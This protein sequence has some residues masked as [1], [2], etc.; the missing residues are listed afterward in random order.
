MLPHS[1]RPPRRRLRRVGSWLAGFVALVGCSR[2]SGTYVVLD[3]EGAVSSQAAIHS[4]EVSLLMGGAQAS[5]V[6]S[7]PGGGDITLSTNATLKIEHGSGPLTVAA[8][9]KSADGQV[10]GTGTGSGEVVAGQ[11]QEI[12][13][14]FTSS[15]G[16]VGPDGGIG[17]DSG[18]DS[19]IDL[20]GDV[21]ADAPG[22]PAGSDRVGD[23]DSG[24]SDL[25]N[26]GADSAD[27][28]VFIDV[29]A[30]ADAAGGV[31]GIN[32]GD[33]AIG[34][35]GAGGAG[36]VAGGAGG[37][38]G[39]AGGAGGIGGAGGAGG[40]GGVTGAGG[41]GGATSAGGTG[42]QDADPDGPGGATAS[43]G[44]SAGGTTGVVALVSEP[45]GLV[46]GEVAVGSKSAP[47]S[48]IIRN[49]GNL[50]APPL[51]IKPL[52]TT[53][54]FALQADAC[55]GKNLA[56]NETCTLVLIFSPTGFGAASDVLT[57]TV[58]GISGTDIILTGTGTTSP[59]VLTLQPTSA[60][61]G[62]VDVGSTG[63]VT[64]TLSNSGGSSS[65]LS[66]VTPSDA[67]I[68]PIASNQCGSL[69]AA[70]ASCTF[71]LNFAP[72]A[73]GPVNGTVSVNPLDATL[74]G[75]GRAY[76]TLTINQTGSGNGTISGT[77]LTCQ[78]GVCT[79]KYATT[80]PS[81]SPAAP[82]VTVTATPD[83]SSTF[84]GWL[85]GGCAG[86][87]TCTVTLGSPMTLSAT[88]TA[89][90]VHQV[91]L[92]AF[93]LASHK[94][95][96]VSSDGVLSCSGSC[97]P[98]PYPA[99]AVVT[100]SANPNPG[101]TFIGWTH[102][103]CHG[104]SPQ[105]KFTLTSDVI[106]SATFGPQAY[107][108]V[109]STTVV[110]GT[111][112]HQAGADNQ[113]AKLAAAA[114]LPGSYRAWL[115]GNSGSGASRIGNGGWVRLDGRIFARNLATLTAPGNP[116]V[117]YPPRIDETGHDVGPGHTPVA[118]G[119]SI[120]ATPS[121][122][123][124]AA[125]GSCADYTST[126]GDLEVGDAI[127]G[128]SSWDASQNM[129]AGCSTA[130]RLYCFRTGMACDLVPQPLPGRHV[131]VTAS[132][133][134]PFGDISNADALCRADA[135]AASLANAGNFVA[136]LATSAASAAS[137]LTV[138]GAP[139]K[140][141]DDVFVFASPTDLATNNLLAAVDL[142]AKGNLYGD[143]GFWSG[144]ASP[145]SVSA[146]D[147]SCQDWSSSGATAHGLYGNTDLSAGADWFANPP[148][149]FSCSETSLHL[150]CAEP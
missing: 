51:S 28:G 78:S 19:Q 90:A 102:G 133:W 92:N 76:V 132:A 147:V 143:F 36:G 55:S 89:A 33:G 62:V 23:V 100:L 11:T 85:G 111:L 40:V 93:G 34:A 135:A 72:T 15:T 45:S 91:G 99:G 124:G 150:L 35:G 122:D 67:S 4:I 65:A 8:V 98:V 138:G 114:G 119:D 117:Y 43:G 130:A 81:G 46:F 125:T 47:L 129:T 12:H 58:G 1:S 9:A 32:G 77:G 140:R 27:G 10:V 95:S 113:C 80:V 139:W 37:A 53:S 149:V 116:A 29:V 64:F 44:S 120:L 106:V 107:M 13:V 21:T 109:T 96:L 97:A 112:G 79:G 39:V 82:T 134:S 128:G 3:F 70:N 137:R 105:C 30:G 118:T 87:N 26:D 148:N 136:L 38:G 104:T 94:G 71:V 73:A 141:V 101:S 2:S 108:F 68:F 57:V 131:F 88:F 103:P 74:S 61:F 75:T 145:G 126:T 7:L 48:T 52:P 59:A 25:G 83:S 63:S 17:T 54:S 42:P 31:G 14:I 86:A 66:M 18:S 24:A 142:V 56:P 41:T 123:G 146:G 20:P 5:S 144:A 6:F 50:S 60:T 49:R 22:D 110:P 16:A 127:A 69:L 121:P 115:S 84:G